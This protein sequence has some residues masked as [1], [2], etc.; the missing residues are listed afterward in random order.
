MVELN[1]AQ[2]VALGNWTDRQKDTQVSAMPLRYTGSKQHLA[3]LLKH[4]LGFFLAAVWSDSRAL[5]TWSDL[6]RPFCIAQRD[7]AFQQASD[8]IAGEEEW[9][10]RN[11]EQGVNLIQRHFTIRGRGMKRPLCRIYSAEEAKPMAGSGRCS[12]SGSGG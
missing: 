8:V 3:L 4:T 10:A 5:L 12:P 7:A 6:D 2:M 9:A 1:P 11:A